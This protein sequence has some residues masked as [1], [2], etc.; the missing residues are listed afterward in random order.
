ML[1]LVTAVVLAVVVSTI[2]QITLVVRELL[3]KVMRVAHLVAVVRH[4][5]LEEAV[6]LVPQEQLELQAVKVVLVRHQA[7]LEHPSLMLEVAVALALVV[8]HLLVVRVVV[9][10]AVWLVLVLL[11]LQI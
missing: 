9:A 7:F 8:A 11:E 4:I 5:P 6:V 1:A 2:P 10:M 3:G